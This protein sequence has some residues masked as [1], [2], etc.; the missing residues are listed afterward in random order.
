VSLP[1]DKS[2]SH[3][4]LILSALSEGSTEIVNFSFNYDC[5][6]TKEILACLG[7]GIRLKDETVVVKGRGLWG[8]RKP[9]RRLYAGDSGTTARLML[10]L[11]CAQRFTSVL[12][13]SVNLRKRPMERVVVPLEKMGAKFSNR[14][15]LPIRIFGRP[16]SGIVYRLPVPSA[17]VKSAILLAG[18]YADK[19]TV[20]IDRFK[21]R[22]H[23]ERML[24]LFKYRD[25]KRLVSPGKIVIP[26]DISSAAFFIAAATILRNS[27]LVLK[28]V[29]INPTRMG[30]VNVLKRMGG[31][32]NIKA[33]PASQ[34]WEPVG[35][36]E[37]KTAALRGTQVKKEEIPSL[38]DELP[39]LMV[40][41]C[42]AEGTTVINDAGELRIKETD[43]IRSMIY[44]LSNM[45]AYIKAQGNRIIIKGL[46]PLYGAKLKSFGDHRTAMSIIIAVL[47][48][49]GGS[50]I[51]DVRCIDKS[52][53][54]FLSILK[55]LLR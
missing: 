26:G 40:C 25:D 50:V 42:L 53:P 55:K 54:K 7:V 12:D 20:V 49:E 51:D 23:T 39:I 3:R 48:A 46:R 30:F 9:N 37:V 35:D 14:E 36:I 16:L 10:G 18:L 24:R 6:R 33:V 52:F 4:A 31:C 27:R 47:S 43:R 32:I 21:S 19:K 2:I 17:Q 1:G 8:L 13:G 38:I 11:L 45:G 22:D 41:A 15:H 34:N 28:N 29:L 44:N 5:L